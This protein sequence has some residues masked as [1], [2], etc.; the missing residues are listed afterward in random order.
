MATHSQSIFRRKHFLKADD[1][2]TMG[3]I[4]QSVYVAPR[5][6]QQRR[7]DATGVKLVQD[8]RPSKEEEEQQARGYLARH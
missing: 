7:H 1:E 6:R 2:R 4:L 8:G 3:Q 5:R